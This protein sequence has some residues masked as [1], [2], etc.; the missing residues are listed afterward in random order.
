[1]R[2]VD[3]CILVEAE[4]RPQASR[5]KSD[6]FDGERCDADRGQSSPAV[7]CWNLL[8]AEGRGVSVVGHRTPWF[9]PRCPSQG[10]AGLA[11]AAAV[12]ALGR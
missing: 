12:T 4:E 1:M 2:W 8:S 10:K 5:A 3:A 11:V 9:V 7:P 6:R